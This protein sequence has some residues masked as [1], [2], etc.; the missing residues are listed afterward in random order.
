M[1]WIQTHCSQSKGKTFQSS[2]INES[3]LEWVVEGEG[4]RKGQI[5][6]ESE[7]QEKN[8]IH[9]PSPSLSLSSLFISSSPPLPPALSFSLFMQAEQ[10]LINPSGFFPQTL[11]APS[12]SF[13]TKILYFFSAV[14]L[15]S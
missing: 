9:S 11:T 7:S 10:F 8:H 4:E 6:N 14:Y 15:A 1:R 13:I 3:S 5:K 12:S 2:P